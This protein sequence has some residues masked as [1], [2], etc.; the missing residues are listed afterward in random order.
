MQGTHATCG[1]IYSVLTLAPV[2]LLRLLPMMPG[3]RG[4]G[5]GWENVY[6]STPYHRVFENAREL[7]QP[8][9]T[10]LPQ[11]MLAQSSQRARRLQKILGEPSSELHDHQRA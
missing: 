7:S 5:Q 2:G 11:K 3:E 10:T 4:T 9:E 6:I 1:A 8:R